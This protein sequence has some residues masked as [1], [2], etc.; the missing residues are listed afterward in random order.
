[1]DRYGMKLTGPLGRAVL[2]EIELSSK[3]KVSTVFSCSN[4]GQISDVSQWISRK[5]FR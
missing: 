4:P 5:N 1:M 2:E 3:S